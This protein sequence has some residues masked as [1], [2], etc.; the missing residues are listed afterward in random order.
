MSSGE[1]ERI[2]LTDD[3]LE[4]LL[5][6]IYAQIMEDRSVT[7][8]QFTSLSQHIPDN[9]SPS[10]VFIAAELAKGIAGYLTEFTNS[11][12][13][14]LKL[15]KILSDK[16]AKT[17][18]SGE[19]ISDHEKLAAQDSIAE[20]IEAKAKRV[21]EQKNSIASA[22]DLLDEPIHTN[23]PGSRVVK[24]IKAGS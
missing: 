7:R 13:K 16:L 17:D 20:F 22:L 4:E 1:N 24:A 8:Q 5:N 21:E 11:T 14:L 23:L 15:A 12:E 6:T 19:V 10:T 9:V 18:G 2:E 3:S